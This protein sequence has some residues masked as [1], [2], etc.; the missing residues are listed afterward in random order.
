MYK[1]LLVKVLNNKPLVLTFTWLYFIV[2]KR[3]FISFFSAVDR[4]TATPYNT[5]VAIGCMGG[6]FKLVEVH[7]SALI[8]NQ[9]TV[10][11]RQGLKS[12]VSV[13]LSDPFLIF[14]EWA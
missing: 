9:F 8:L 7:A 2:F 4:H 3:Y 13:R 1:P 12:R 6:D 14:T 10:E 11:S 5:V